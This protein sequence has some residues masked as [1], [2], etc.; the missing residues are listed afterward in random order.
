MEGPN[1]FPVN[2]KTLGAGMNVDYSIYAKVGNTMALLCKNVVLTE[3]LI[4]KL[5]ARIYPEEVVYVQ[6]E[7]RYRV[8]A[9]SPFLKLVQKEIEDHV[10]YT[11]IKDQS[12]S[13]LNILQESHVYPD[14]VVDEISLTMIDTV[15][16]VEAY[17]IIQCINGIRQ[18]NEY[19][20]THG[21][22]VG[23]LNGLI[24]KWLN[25]SPAEIATLVRIGL[26]HDIGKVRIPERIVNKPFELTRDEFEVM[27][28]HSM[29]SY[30]ILVEAGETNQDILLGVKQHHERINGS[31]YP[32]GLMLEQIHPFARITAVSDIYD[33][34]VAQRV[35]KDANSP[36][37][38]L[39]QF[40]KGQFSELDMDLVHVFLRYMPLELTGKQVVLSDGN[41]GRVRYIDPMDCEYPI[42]ECNGKVFATN[43]DLYC[44]S[45]YVEK[46]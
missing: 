36:F 42:V 23:L 15:S 41:I 8:L 12:K 22:N 39:K 17:P 4:E 34:M 45:M 19:L 26:L 24:G 27:K 5:K 14:E 33:A 38:V 20:F 10:G 13:L 29:H 16:T 9:E 31:G 3:Y 28:Q 1:L 7:M 44:V 30:N 21:T 11:Q 37:V 2:I 40:F 18:A 25:Y 35:Y 46:T 32:E 43:P 6:Q